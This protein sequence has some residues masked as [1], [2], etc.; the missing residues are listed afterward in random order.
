M[1]KISKKK[2]EE[3]KQNIVNSCLSF[4]NFDFE[5]KLTDNEKKQKLILKEK[6]KTSFIQLNKAKNG[7]LNK[8]KNFGEEK[9]FFGE[10]FFLCE[11][12]IENILLYESIKGLILDNIYP[13]T[14]NFIIKNL[15]INSKKNKT[16]LKIS[17]SS[18]IR[19]IKKKTKCDILKNN[20][21]IKKINLIKKPTIFLF[22]QKNEYIKQN[23]FLEIFN[24]CNSDLKKIR[25]VLNSKHNDIRKK[26]DIEFCVKFV[27]RVLG[28]FFDK[29]L[30]EVDSLKNGIGLEEEFDK[31]NSQ[32][33]FNEKKNCQEIFLENKKNSQEIF[34]K[35][36]NKKSEE[37][38]FNEKNK[39][40]SEEIFLK[41]KKYNEEIFLEE[42]NKKNGVNKNNF[43][44]KNNME[45]N[46][47]EIVDKKKE[48][49][50]KE[51]NF[52]DLE[53]EKRIHEKTE[54]RIK[55]IGKI[56]FSDFSVKTEIEKKSLSKKSKKYSESEKKIKIPKKIF[57]QNYIDFEIDEKSY[58]SEKNYSI[59]SENEKNLVE[60]LLSPTKFLKNR[61]GLEE[62]I[63]E[64]KKK[65]VYKK[66]PNLINFSSSNG[67][68]IDSSEVE[69]ERILHKENEK[70]KI[71][72]N[73]NEILNENIGIKNKIENVK[74]NL[75]IRKEI[76]NKILNEKIG[77]RNKI[78]NVKET[79]NNV[80]KNEKKVN[81]DKNE[82]IKQIENDNKIIKEKNNK[83][84][85]EKKEKE[86]IIHYSDLK[87]EE[88]SVKRKSMEEKLVDYKK[89]DLDLSQEKFKEKKKKIFEE[90][91]KKFEEEKKIY[92]PKKYYLESK[93]NF[94]MIEKLTNYYYNL[95]KDDIL[96]ITYN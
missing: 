5:K 53:E 33:F 90:E 14:K 16:L 57:D 65:L 96:L 42:K 93:E 85:K 31:Y 30:L 83:I 77:I 74:E 4:E 86:Y 64:K 27:K 72:K 89:Y 68:G 71:K 37:F 87:Q 50:N 8:K 15:V 1:K 11:N 73:E 7:I 34:L 60:E 69:E 66:N 55:K 45:N 36:K 84:I 44:D 95:L 18:I 40:Y 91:K 46:K 3:I 82:K 35:N 76:E 59:N 26:E 2:R 41:N 10:N 9:I 25:I 17:F 20:D 47:I 43:E 12:E 6:S 38:F 24:K 58:F 88:N 39:K 80:I 51:I 67:S 79:E 23:D 61:L 70:S 28:G 21:I 48:K 92:S 52:S 22:S 56:D 19:K 78:E 54:K 75:E 13:N 81:E 49:K 29:G 62:K 32:I 63:D 94:E